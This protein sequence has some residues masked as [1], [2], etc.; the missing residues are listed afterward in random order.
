[1]T[2]RIKELAKLNGL[3]EIMNLVIEECSELIKEMT[4]SHRGIGDVGSIEEEIA[5]VLLVIYQLMHLLDISEDDIKRITEEKVER[6][7]QTYYE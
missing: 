1:M 3:D 7:M 5:D 6:T 4:K 2:E